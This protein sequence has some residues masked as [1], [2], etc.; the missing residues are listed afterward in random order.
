MKKKKK[1]TAQSVPTR[2]LINHPVNASK[3]AINIFN[4]DLGASR[5]EKAEVMGWKRELS[6]SV[7]KFGATNKLSNNLTV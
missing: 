4:P 3:F 6:P 2:S 1:K 5:G 7:L